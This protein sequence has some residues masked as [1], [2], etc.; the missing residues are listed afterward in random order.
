MNRDFSNRIP[1]EVFEGSHRISAFP[2]LHLAED[3]LP[4]LTIEEQFAICRRTSMENQM[5]NAEFET[6]LE[7]SIFPA[8][9]EA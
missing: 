9:E 7:V 1:N 3:L 2:L 5:T 8:E 4:Y 6:H